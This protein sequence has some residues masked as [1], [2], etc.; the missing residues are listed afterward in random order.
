MNVY[1]FMNYND[2]LE[3]PYTCDSYKLNGNAGVICTFNH[4]IMTRK[5]LSS[6]NT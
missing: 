5:H 4:V 6:I 2:L 1:Y 3:N